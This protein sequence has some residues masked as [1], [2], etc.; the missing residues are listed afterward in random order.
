[1]IYTTTKEQT[2]EEIYEERFKRWE[3]MGVS[4]ESIRKANLPKTL[5][6][7]LPKGTK[8]IIPALKTGK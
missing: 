8:I 2:I 4:V 1:M 5:N 3:K 6:G 7:K